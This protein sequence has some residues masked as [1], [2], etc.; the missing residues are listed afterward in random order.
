MQCD[1]ESCFALDCLDLRVHR[2]ITLLGCCFRLAC[3]HPSIDHFDNHRAFKRYLQAGGGLFA[4]SEREQLFNTNTSTTATMDTAAS[5]SQ[6]AMHAHSTTTHAGA[7]IAPS[8][9]AATFSDLSWTTAILVLVATLL[10]L[11]QSVYRYKKAHLPGAKWTIP[12]IGKFAGESSRRSLSSCFFTQNLCLMLSHLRLACSNDGKVQEDLG[13]SISCC[14]R[15]QHVGYLT[16]LSPSV[17]PCS[18]SR[19]TCLQ[20]PLPS[21]PCRLGCLDQARACR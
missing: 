19:P 6:H 12:V 4:P 13:Y 10:V 5:H 7:S 1:V 20:V 15:V 16:S 9:I 11:E 2:R 18:C 17:L 8:N 14:Q 21:I 3:V